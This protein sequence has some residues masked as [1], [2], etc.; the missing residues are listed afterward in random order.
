[1]SI[2]DDFHQIDPNR[3]LDASYWASFGFTSEPSMREKIIAV[4]I[5]DVGR[6][7][8]M[9]FNAKFT[10][11]ALEIAP[12]LVNHHFGGRDELLAEATL[13]CYRNYVRLM[14]EA[15]CAAKSD[16]KVRLRTWIETQIEWTSRMAGWGP[17]LNYPTSSMTITRIIDEK[18]RKEMTDWS[19]LHI[20]RLIVL[21]GDVKRDRVSEANLEFGKLPRARL[22]RDMKVAMLAGSVGWSTL[23]VSIWKAGRHLPTGLVKE[24]GIIEKQIL[25][26]HVDRIMDTVTG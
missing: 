7:G 8:P 6:V 19:E 24:L 4:T 18:Y 14:W 1:M 21:V 10:C 2:G 11:Q 20:A 25:K 3:V 16:P 5:D 12:S 9:T 13:I 15:V 26:A 23:G 17:I 22:L